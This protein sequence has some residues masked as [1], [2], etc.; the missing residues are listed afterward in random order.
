M[1]FLVV[2]MSH[3][4]AP[5][6]VLEHAAL[7]HDGV[8][9]L[10]HRALDSDDVG[11][12]V[13]V[14]TCNRVEIYVETD[15]FHGSVDEI[16]SILAE[17]AQLSRDEFAANAYIHYDEAVVAHLFTVAAG[18]DSMVVGESQ[19]LGQVRSALHAAQSEGTVGTMLNTLF[20]QALRVGKRGHAETGID[21]LGASVV[22]EAYD[23][24]A[25]AMMGAHKQF[26]VVG[27]GSM[28]GLAVA[29]LLRR[30]VRA[31]QITVVNR[32]RFRAD[33]LAST[34]GVKVADWSE[35][36]GCLA[37]SDVLISCT[38]ANGIVFDR[39]L[40]K[41]AVQGRS[42]AIIDLALPHDVDQRLR[43]LAEVTL[44][45]IAMLAEVLSGTEVA[46]D[47]SA[48]RSLV[49]EEVAAFLVAREASRVTP[50]V[51]A[52]RTMATNV[53]ATEIDRLKDRHPDL[54]PTLEADIS[55]SLK[56]IADKLIHSPTVRVQEL[57]AGPDGQTYA[58][59]LADLFSLDPDAVNAVRRINEVGG[60]S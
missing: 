7:D 12:S 35:I 23:L 55:A 18:L 31:N 46:A 16:S 13:I 28:A 27:A 2:G 33:Q 47:V 29:T 45:D 3:R 50:T 6:R 15:R 32:T 5:I 25:G 30:D 26:L 59:A 4:S 51:V 22:S 58:D 11:E 21:R 17:H 1:T 37:N 10:L 48:V 14:S 38:G 49:S 56:R 60:D 19:I 42:F 53:V 9:K 52:L 20:Q 44:V 57:A 43:D 8:I 39:D 54:D 34:H 36:D 24:A 41:D 40:I